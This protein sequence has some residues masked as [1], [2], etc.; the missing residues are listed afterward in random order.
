MADILIRVDADDWAGYITDL[1]TAVAA[2]DAGATK[3]A[4][5]A[6]LTAID[7]LDTHA[8]ADPVAT[9]NLNRPLHRFQVD[10]AA[11]LEGFDI[12]TVQGNAYV[13]KTAV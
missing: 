6:A 5:E 10:A 8:I 11:I 1:D 13:E 7:A 12:K 4:G 3:T 9:I 2:L